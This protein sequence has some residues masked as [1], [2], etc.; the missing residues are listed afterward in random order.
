MAEVERIATEKLAIAEPSGAGTC[1]A[2]AARAHRRPLRQAR[3]GL[4]REPLARAR[5]LAAESGSPTTRAYTLRVE[6]TRPPSRA[7]WT[8]PRSCSSRHV[9]CSSKAASR[10]RSR[11]RSTRSGRSLGHGVT[12]AGRKSYC[13]T[14]SGCSR[15]SRIVALSSRASASWLRRCSGKIVS[16]MPN[17]WRSK[18]SRPSAPAMSLPARRR[19]PRW[20]SPRSAGERRRGRAAA[21]RVDRDPAPHRVPPPR[22]RAACCARRLPAR[23]EP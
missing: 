17:G 14:R 1:R 7:V 22:D 8:R 21:S 20:G 5:E 18:R 2:G 3:A 10:S 16:T 13:V 4:A 11:A 15:R 6:A 12:W 23:A 19:G 9:S